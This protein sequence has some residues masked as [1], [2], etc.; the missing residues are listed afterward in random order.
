MTNFK[1]DVRITCV[2]CKKEQ[3]IK[4][5]SLDGLVYRVN[6]GK[7]QNC[8]PNMP[9]AER[10]LFISGTCGSCFKKMC[11]YSKDPKDDN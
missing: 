10:E 8:F 7:I 5:V 9:I 3:T 11:S 1:I 4:D 6:G 2:A